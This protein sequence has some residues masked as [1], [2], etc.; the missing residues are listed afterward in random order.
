VATNLLGSFT[1]FTR[2]QLCPTD[3]PDQRAALRRLTRRLFL[4]PYF[5]VAQQ[6]LPA[7]ALIQCLARARFGTWSS[8]YRTF[9]GA[10]TGPRP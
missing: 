6:G 1:G 10:A 5:S 8:D 9:F 3:P 7:L 2:A 4:N